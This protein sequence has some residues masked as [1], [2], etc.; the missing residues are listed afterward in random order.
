[1]N[2]NTIRNNR[3]ALVVLGTVVLLAAILLATG[4][5]TWNINL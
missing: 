1:M 3:A 5:A 4:L 2:L